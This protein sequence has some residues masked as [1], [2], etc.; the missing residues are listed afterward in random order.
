ML[1]N[2]YTINIPK[3]AR[4]ITYLHPEE[5]VRFNF[6]GINYSFDLFARRVR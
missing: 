3:R 2:R 4:D 6:K 1:S 5:I